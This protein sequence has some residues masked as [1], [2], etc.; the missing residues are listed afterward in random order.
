M[1]LIII[2]HT[3]IRPL[4]KYRF[5]CNKH[6]FFVWV[7]WLHR[8]YNQIQC[9]CECYWYFGLKKKK[10][11]CKHYQQ[12]F[13]CC[14]N[15]FECFWY[16]RQGWVFEI[17]S[18]HYAYSFIRNKMLRSIELIRVNSCIASYFIIEYLRF[19]EFRWRWLK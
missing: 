2:T 11:T 18:T 7:L 13:V 14:A 6:I 4:Q 9:T 5:N 16:F 1:T 19:G 15:I 8:I 12:L 10:N 3:H 17:C